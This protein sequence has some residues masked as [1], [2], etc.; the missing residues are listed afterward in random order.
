MEGERKGR[1]KVGKVMVKERERDVGRLGFEARS[2]FVQEVGMKT[3][4]KRKK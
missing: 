3:G 1:R 4:P 2:V